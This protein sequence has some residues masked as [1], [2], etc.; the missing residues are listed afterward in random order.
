M[1][2]NCTLKKTDHLCYNLL[3]AHTLCKLPEF[4]DVGGAL[5]VHI[6]K[7]GILSL[8]FRGGRGGVSVR[9]EINKYIFLLTEANLSF[10]SVQPLLLSPPIY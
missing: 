3:V 1:S 8:P 6:P 10:Y 9:G 4:W 5:P 2:V 7:F